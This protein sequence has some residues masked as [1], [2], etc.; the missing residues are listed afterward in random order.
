MKTT[1]FRASVLYLLLAVFVSGIVY[2]AFSIFTNGQDWVMQAYNGY[3]YY[4]DTASNK[5][6]ILDRNNVLLAYLEDDERVYSSN[7]S[8]RTALLHTVGDSSGYISTSVQSTLGATLL[9]YNIFTGLNQ[10]PYEEEFFSK[11]ITLTLDANLCAIAYEALNGYNG[12]VIVSNY[13]TGEVLCKVSTPSYDP[14]DIPSDLLTNSDYDG[15]FLDN[16]ISS[17]YTPGSIFKL[18]VAACAIENDM[19]DYVCTCSGS[20]S[21]DGS[22]V[23]CLGTHG[24]TDLES[25]LGNSCNIYFASLALELGS[26]KLQETAEQLGFN[27][28]FSFSDFSSTASKIDLTTA[29]DIE[30]AWAGVGQYTLQVNAT[31]M[32]V[33]MQAIANGGVS[34][35]LNLTDQT[36]FEIS[37]SGDIELMSAST[38]NALKSYMEINVDEYYSKSSFVEWDI[39]A[40]TGTGEVDGQNP[41][42]WIVGFSSNPDTPYAFSI[43]VEDSGYGMAY[44]G[45]IA[46]KILAELV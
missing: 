27:V 34:T 22:T 15:V 46:E 37:S 3:I 18:V 21:V 41:N 39:C 2:L 4:G 13:E 16:T 32:L 9:G 7:E 14:M 40:K 17:T 26:E 24:E 45:A 36:I 43:V 12:A 42:S 19:E 11:D 29:S 1:G 30:L 28:S 38:A 20:L 44:A 8:I 6:D 35:Q 23:T 5:G 33:L 10:L 25:G 31:H